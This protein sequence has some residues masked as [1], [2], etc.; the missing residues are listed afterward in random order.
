MILSN[1]ELLSLVELRK[2]II[3]PITEDTIRE[4]GVDLSIGDEICELVHYSDSDGVVLKAY[5]KYDEDYLR[6]NFYRCWHADKYTIK[7]HRRYL[8]TTLEYVKLPPDIMGFVN[9]RSTVAR[10]GLFIPPTIIDAGFEG[11]ITVELIGGEFPIE[12]KRGQRFLHIVFAEISSPVQY[13]G[14]YQYQSGVKLPVL[15][16]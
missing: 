11:Q 13:R 7:P 5:E 9:Q 10:L 15:P 3:K 12:L 16:L 8:L 1:K 4:N 2:L 6:R 14:K